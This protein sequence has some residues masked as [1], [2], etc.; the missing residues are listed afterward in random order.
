MVE[1]GPG[2]QNRLRLRL[3]SCLGLDI[4]LGLSLVLGDES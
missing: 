2:L 1:L 3:G 4:G